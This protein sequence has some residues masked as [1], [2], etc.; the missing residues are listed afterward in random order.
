MIR[1]GILGASGF[2]GARLVYYLSRHPEAEIVFATSRQNKGKAISELYGNL[3]GLCD[4]KFIDPDDADT[5]S[6]DLLFTCA[7]DQTSMKVVPDY[8]ENGISVIDLAGD[9]RMDTAES[10]EQ[11][12]GQ[13]HTSPDYIKKAVFGLT[14]LYREKIRKTKF[15]SN[16]GCYPTSVILGLAPLLKEG[17]IDCSSIHVNSVSGISGAGRDLKLFKLFYEAD[18]N[19]MPYKFG[20]THKHVGEIEQELSKIAGETCMVTFAPHV[21]PMKTGIVSTILVNMA[22]KVS[23][24][25]IDNLYK[26]AYDNEFFVRYYP[27]KLPESKYV[28]D[29][30]FCDIGIY[31]VEEAEKVIVVSTICNL[32]KGA[33]GQ[34]VQNMNVMFGFDEKEGLL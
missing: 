6:I 32:G 20:R 16:P 22:K 24:E 11:W 21:V 2:T 29:T 33:S 27:D 5:R 26:N 30:N 7:P 17:I 18:S 19:V 9:Y 13:P 23:R 8:Y 10:Y 4:V 31:L 14:E 34:A 12:Y 3:R 15:V 25:D 28:A 1:V